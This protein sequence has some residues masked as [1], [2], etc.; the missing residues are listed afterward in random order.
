MQVISHAAA[1][2]L[3]VL[4]LVLCLIMLAADPTLPGGR[5]IWLNENNPDAAQWLRL[6]SAGHPHMQVS[7]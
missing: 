5:M 3:C 4:T 1:F 6:I 2:L 7:W